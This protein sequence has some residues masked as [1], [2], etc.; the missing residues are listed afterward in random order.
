[1]NDVL[2]FRRLDENT[3]ALTFGCEV[4]Q[5]FVDRS[6]RQCRAFVPDGMTLKYR[7]VPSGAVVEMDGRRVFQ[8]LMNAV[9]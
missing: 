6:C 2:D 1:M 5:A 7:V 3:L 4:L 9:R 8:I